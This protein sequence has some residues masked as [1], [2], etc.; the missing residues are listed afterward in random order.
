[1]WASDENPAKSKTIVGL[2]I[3]RSIGLVLLFD[4]S[5][6]LQIRQIALVLDIDH[7]IGVYEADKFC[8]ADPFVGYRFSLLEFDR[9]FV[10]IGDAEE[11]FINRIVRY[12]ASDVCEGACID[13]GFLPQF[14]SGAAISILAFQGRSASGGGKE[15]AV[16]GLP[17]SP[18]HQQIV[19]ID[20]PNKNL[21]D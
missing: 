21:A 7:C 2:T 1:M 15:T 18:L 16:V 3:C 11:G 14:P 9:V 12:E 4:I 6:L 5:H 13:A 17:V 19:A 10:T 8:F 20:M